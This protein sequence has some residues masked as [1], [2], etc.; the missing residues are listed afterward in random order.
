M[1]FNPSNA[2][3]VQCYRKF[4]KSVKEAG[5]NAGE[6]LAYNAIAISYQMLGDLQAALSYHARHG[7]VAT[8][9]RGQVRDIDM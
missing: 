6:C 9:A 5:D 8:D 7:K 1:N 3:F 4:L 2:H